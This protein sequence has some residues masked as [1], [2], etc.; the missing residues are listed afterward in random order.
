M[1]LQRSARTGAAAA[2][3]A[4]D[5]LASDGAWLLSSGRLLARI[6]AVDGHQLPTSP[7]DGALRQLLDV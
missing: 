1:L 3:I 2:V 7:L 5:L 4:A 6:T